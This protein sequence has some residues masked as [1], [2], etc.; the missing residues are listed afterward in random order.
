MD[1]PEL[2]TAFMKVKELVQQC[3]YINNKPVGV[4]FDLVVMPVVLGGVNGTSTQHQLTQVTET[5][6]NHIA[7][8]GLSQVQ[9]YWKCTLAHCYNIDN[10]CWV[11]IDEGEELPG[12]LER[13]HEVPGPTI[14]NWD[15]ELLHGTSTLERPS[16]NIVRQLYAFKA[17]EKRAAKSTATAISD[18]KLDNLLT[19][20]TVLATVQVTS[21]LSDVAAAGNAGVDISDLIR[22]ALGG[23]AARGAPNNDGV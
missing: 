14:M 18:K 22:K 16:G 6:A 3:K 4:T 9:K 20:V 13:H 15:R 21:A 2:L 1:E 19:M 5:Q 17:R 12:R 8:R 23:G 7:G 11:D 10:T